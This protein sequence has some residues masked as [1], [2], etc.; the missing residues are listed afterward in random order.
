MPGPADGGARFLVDWDLE[1]EL[2]ASLRGGDAWGASAPVEIA[3]VI[4]TG[5][6]RRRMLQQRTT[7]QVAELLSENVASD[8]R[9]QD[10]KRAHSKGGERLFLQAGAAYA[11]M[12]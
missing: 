12:N 11:E 3:V 10:S 8:S 6:H 4:A 2:Y 5:K 9:R 7:M 1:M